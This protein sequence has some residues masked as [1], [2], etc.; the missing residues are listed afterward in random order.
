MMLIIGYGNSLRG[1]DGLG[2]YISRRLRDML[3]RPDVEI[4]SQYQ[5]TPELVEPISRADRVIFIDARTGAVPGAI[6]CARVE[7]VPDAGP[8]MHHVSPAG[9]LA[10]SWGLYGRHP[11]AVLFSVAGDC[12]DYGEG[13]SPAVQAAVPALLARILYHVKETMADYA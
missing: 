5:L 11:E 9:L 10:A 3:T 12:F 8:L 1:D 6:E 2:E 13:L 7:P 4:L